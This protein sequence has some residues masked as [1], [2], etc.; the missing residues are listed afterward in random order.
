MT[1]QQ[2]RIVG[3]YYSVGIDLF[4]RELNTVKKLSLFLYVPVIYSNKVDGVF[5]DKTFQY[6]SAPM[7]L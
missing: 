5:C 7:H 2:P 6:V 1:A 4:E 3:V